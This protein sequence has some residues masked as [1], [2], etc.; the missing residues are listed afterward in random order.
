[1]RYIAIFLLLINIGYFGWTRFGSAQG[2]QPA[3]NVSRPLINSGLILVSE[4]QE[5]LAA[6]AKNRCYSIA[7]FDSIDD[8]SGFI[9]AIDE[10]GFETELKLSGG[11]LPSQYRVYLPPFS[12]RGIATITLDDLSDSLSAAAMQVET[13]LITRGLLE[14]GIALG[15][16]SE[17]ENAQD[18][19]QGVTALGY[20]PE[21]EELPRSTGEIQVQLRALES[22]LLENPE[23][24]ELTVDRPDLIVTENLCETIA[25]GTQFP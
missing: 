24:L 1:M 25:Q 20:K 17:Y 15:V 19:L 5:Q 3:R 23:W 2:P 7:S 10:S 13:Y 11:P 14:N 18:V 12:S 4:Y 8:A 21:I 6:Q 16:F 22:D 9:S